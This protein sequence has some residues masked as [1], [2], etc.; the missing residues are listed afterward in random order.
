MQ[1][2]QLNTCSF[3]DPHLMYAAS[4][5]EG[6]DIPAVPINEIDPKY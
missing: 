6:Y 3:G 2:P 4:F 1:F 5:D